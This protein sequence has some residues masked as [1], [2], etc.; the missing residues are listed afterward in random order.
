MR[1]IN[2]WKSTWEWK[3]YIKKK[4]LWKMNKK[5]CRQWPCPFCCL[6]EGMVCFHG[7]HL[8]KFFLSI[9]VCIWKKRNE[10]FLEIFKKHF[11][12][13]FLY[14]LLF[15]HFEL[16]KNFYYS[17][18]LTPLFVFHKMISHTERDVRTDETTL[19]K[20]QGLLFLKI[21]KKDIRN[22]ICKMS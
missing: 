18:L 1:R 2:E 7:L 22:I 3:I 21:G 11:K 14:L 9:V 12:S 17:T 16:V 6:N 13:G 8:M 4:W 15:I 20:V 5:V 10:K 19:F